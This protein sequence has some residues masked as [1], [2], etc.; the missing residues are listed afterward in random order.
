EG[1]DEHVDG[2]VGGPQVDLAVRGGQL[3]EELE[4]ER[5]P[6]IAPGRVDLSVD[7]AEAAI[8]R[9]H[10]DEALQNP[11]G[12]PQM[13][14]RMTIGRLGGDERDDSVDDLPMPRP[15]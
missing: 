15:G 1:A 7:A 12:D 11:P 4:V 6:R 5:P 13:L 9:T 8:N 2:L 14:V 3:D 10:V